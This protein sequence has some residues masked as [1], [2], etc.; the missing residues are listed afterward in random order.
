MF[1]S[2]S[3]YKHAIRGLPTNTSLMMSNDNLRNIFS[4]LAGTKDVYSGCSYHVYRTSRIMELVQYFKVVV[5]FT[6]N[7]LVVQVL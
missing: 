3:S 2:C 1:Y 6:H 7:V 4:K 5:C